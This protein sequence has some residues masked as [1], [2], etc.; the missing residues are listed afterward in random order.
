MKNLLK[1]EGLFLFGFAPL[2][3][4]GLDYGWG[5]HALRFFAP[6]LSMIG[7]LANPRFGA[8]TFTLWLMFAPLRAILLGHS[9]F[10]RVFGYDLK[11]E[12]AFGEDWEIG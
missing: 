7:Y 4:S 5:W 6:D 1:L 12:D 9:S 2:L 8:L 3:F 11:H 10:D